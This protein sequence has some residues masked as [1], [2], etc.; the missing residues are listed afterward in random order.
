MLLSFHL[1]NCRP[2]NVGLPTAITESQYLGALNGSFPPL[3]SLAG[4]F[5][6][7]PVLI[8]FSS[9][10]SF[11]FLMSPLHFSQYPLGMQ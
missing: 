5:L 3:P 6:F 4:S 10:L 2:L 8:S 11:F 7:H 9:P 1:V